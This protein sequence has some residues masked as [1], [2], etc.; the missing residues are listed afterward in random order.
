M[1]TPIQQYPSNRYEIA[2][3]FGAYDILPYEGEVNDKHWNQKEKEK[4]MNSGIFPKTTNNWSR[5]LLDYIIYFNC[6]FCQIII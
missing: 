3:Y 2:K 5:N 1:L 4:K 6:I